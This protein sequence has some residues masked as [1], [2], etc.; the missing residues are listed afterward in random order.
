MSPRPGPPGPAGLLL[1]EWVAAYLA[2][3]G[4]RGAA[5]RTLETRAAHLRAFVTWAAARGVKHGA[6]LSS[7]LV[8]DYQGHLHRHRGE[9]DR[10][11]ATLT[12]RGMLSDLRAFGRW[13]VTEGLVGAGDPFAVLELPKTPAALPADLLTPAQIAALVAACD[14][15]TP[16]G[17]RN[18]ALLEMAAAIGIT[19]RELAALRMSDVETDTGLLSVRPLERGRARTVP[20][21]TTAARWLRSYLV[22]ARPPLTL[23]RAPTDALLVSQHGRP[24]ASGDAAHIAREAARCAGVPPRRVLSALKDSLA[25]R[26]LE[27]GC[28]PRYLAALF[29]HADL[30]SVARYRRMSVGELRE[31]HRRYH[32]AER[33]S[34]DS[35][36]R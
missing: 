20:L 16:L 10:G 12:Q 7:S 9:T 21:G 18:R 15:T 22:E 17:L 30:Q 5:Q 11:Y 6:L 13:C 25:V 3:Q 29:G 24:L 1:A 34:R 2:D 8:L 36:A 23:G 32:P 19:G 28:D 4:A 31:I 26:L 35:D 33:Q 27:A 14:V